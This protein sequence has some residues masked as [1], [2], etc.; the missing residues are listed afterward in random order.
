M[1]WSIFNYPRSFFHRYPVLN[2]LHIITG[3]A[4][5][6]ASLMSYSFWPTPVL[7]ISRA[8]FLVTSIGIWTIGLM[9]II[10]IHMVVYKA[11]GEKQIQVMIV[12]ACFSPSKF[13][14]AISGWVF[15]IGG[16]T[17]IAASILQLTVFT[18]SPVVRIGTAIYIF[19]TAC[20][21]FA[22]YL[23]FCLQHSQQWESYAENFL[24]YWLV[25]LYNC[26]LGFYLC[27]S[28]LLLTANI[29]SIAHCPGECSSIIVSSFLVAGGVMFLLGAFA[30]ML[31][32]CL[33]RHFVI[34]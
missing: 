24:Y 27:A 4:L 7:W 13:T 33:I 31:Q 17:I 15:F 22:T 25:T 28:I 5:L 30:K 19:S 16:K 26:I 1:A 11:R 2:W 10:E 9:E 32:A 3:L 12:D 18:P 14:G 23:G 8:F 21:S 6:S 20:F 34:K 29:I